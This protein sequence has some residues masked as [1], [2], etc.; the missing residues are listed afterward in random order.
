[1]VLVMV[2][3]GCLVFF[4]WDSGGEGCSDYLAVRMGQRCTCFKA[5]VAEDLNVFYVGFCAEF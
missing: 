1:M 2:V 3:F 5:V 4:F